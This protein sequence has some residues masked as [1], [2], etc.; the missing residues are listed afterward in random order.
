MRAIG[1]ACGIMVLAT[2][3]LAE[4]DQGRGEDIA[5]QWCSECH[6]T[7]IGDTGSDQ[8]PTWRGI[9]LDPAKDEAYLRSFLR[10]P[11]PAM[12]NIPL[13]GQDIDDVIAYIRALAFE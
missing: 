10:D 7:E 9:A 3:A 2:A 6:A 5:R 4:G 11:H 1:Y 13:T 8:A 12:R